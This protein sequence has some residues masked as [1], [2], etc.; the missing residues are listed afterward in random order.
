MTRKQKKVL[1]AQLDEMMTCQ[2]IVYIN[3]RKRIVVDKWRVT[4]VYKE[5]GITEKPKIF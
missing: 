5:L 2:Y 3:G 4:R 1:Q